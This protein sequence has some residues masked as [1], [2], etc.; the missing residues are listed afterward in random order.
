MV[1]ALFCRDFIQSMIFILLAGSRGVWISK[2]IYRC[3][4]ARLRV[5]VLVCRHI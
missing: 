3:A 5:R 2:L 4:R 1:H